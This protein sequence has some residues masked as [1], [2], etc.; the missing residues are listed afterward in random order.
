LYDAW[1]WPWPSIL[2]IGAGS[3]YAG[4]VESASEKDIAGLAPM[5]GTVVEE[6]TRFNSLVP[7]G[8]QRSTVKTNRPC[9]ISLTSHSLPVLIS[10]TISLTHGG[11]VIGRRSLSP[12][13]HIRAR[14]GCWMTL[15][16]YLLPFS[17][18]ITDGGS[19]ATGCCPG[20]KDA[21]GSP[22]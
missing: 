7:S 16:S 11:G 14:W 12:K 20:A 2:K 22:A 17:S 9:S 18:L 19:G 4:R 5:D 3:L 6:R 15:N 1:P 13:P 10:V 8:D 21:S